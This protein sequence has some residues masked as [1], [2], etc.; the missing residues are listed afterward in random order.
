[1]MGMAWGVSYH[2]F[3]ELVLKYESQFKSINS[4]FIGVFLS[5]WIGAKIFFIFTTTTIASHRYTQTAN[6]WLGGGFVFYG[7]LIFALAFTTLF[8]KIKKINIKH[9]N[10]LGV[11]IPPLAFGHSIGRVGCFLTGCCYGKAWPNG[12]MTAYPVQIFEAVF[13]IIIGFVG[14][15]LLKK[16]KSPLL[17]Y[18][19]SYSSSRFLLEFL[20]G[21]TI[22]GIWFFGLSTS[23]IVSIFLITVTCIAFVLLRYKRKL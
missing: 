22:R 14:L 9:S 12:L 10:F 13:L 2:I 3:K 20:R 21:D 1:M 19:L 23:Q 16:Q 7:G 5:S 17:F 4:Y 15:M 18:I 8:V 11:L 6:F